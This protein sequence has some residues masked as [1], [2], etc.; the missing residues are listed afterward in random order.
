VKFS[1]QLKVHRM[2][3]WRKGWKLNTP[4]TTAV[5]TPNFTPPF[6]GVEI[7]ESTEL[8]GNS[9]DSD[10]SGDSD[11]GDSGDSGGSDSGSV[12]PGVGVRHTT[13][14]NPFCLG[15]VVFFWVEAPSY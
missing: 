13:P 4:L 1:C 3:T 14:L 6:Q 2:W 15:W 5:F 9:G 10:D 11:N 7:F 8:C 12:A